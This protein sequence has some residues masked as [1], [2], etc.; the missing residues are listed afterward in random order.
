MALQSKG[1]INQAH[2][3]MR[4]VLSQLPLGALE[5]FSQSMYMYMLSINNLSFYTYNTFKG[6]Y[7]KAIQNGVNI[8]DSSMLE[9]GAVKPLGTGIFWNFS[10]VVKYT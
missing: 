9:M 3:G 1:Q 5:L 10:V 7:D 4:K 6:F 2:D 8:K